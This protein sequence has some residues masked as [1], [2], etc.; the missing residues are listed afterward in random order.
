MKVFENVAFGQTNYSGFDRDNW[1]TRTGSQHRL[2]CNDISKEN[3]KS[4]IRSKES[5]VGC[6]YSILLQLPYFV[7][8]KT[9][10]LT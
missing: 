4:E 1:P 10:S 7:Q 9:Q 8:F 3:T 5:E 6:R 2:A